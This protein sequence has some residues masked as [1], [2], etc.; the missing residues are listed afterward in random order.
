MSYRLDVVTTSVADA[1]SHAGGLMFD[2]GRAGWRVAVVT[3]AAPYSQFWATD[4]LATVLFEDLLPD[5]QLARAH[6]GGTHEQSPSPE[7]VGGSPHG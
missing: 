2:R 4:A 5:G 3:D 7:L 6:A 1:I